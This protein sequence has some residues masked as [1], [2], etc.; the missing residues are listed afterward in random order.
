MSSWDA[1]SEYVE[2]M[3]HGHHVAGQGPIALQ[4]VLG[5][6]LKSSQGRRRAVLAMMYQNAA[7]YRRVHGE[8]LVCC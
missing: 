5:H 7:S 8:T 1:G 4:H 3:D 2:R 6:N